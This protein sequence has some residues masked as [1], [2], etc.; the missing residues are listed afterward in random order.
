MRY[1]IGDYKRDVL[2]YWIM[3][4]RLLRVAYYSKCL[5]EKKKKQNSKI[6]GYSWGYSAGKEKKKI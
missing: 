1:C 3:P 4:E 5:Q 2:Y 6:K